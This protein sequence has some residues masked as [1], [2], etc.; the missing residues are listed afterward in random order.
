MSQTKNVRTLQRRVVSDKSDKTVTVY[1]ERK[2]RHPLYGKIIRKSTKI[3]AHD[4]NNQYKIGDVV[5]IAESRPLSKT[6]S[7]V[8]L[9]LV[10]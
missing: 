1:V 7:W 6:K 4:E 9:K 2:V 8:V 3:H 10:E 5:V